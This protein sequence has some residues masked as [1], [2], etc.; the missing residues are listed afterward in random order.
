MTKTE[1]R[2][3][4]RE[5]IVVAANRHRQA[6]NARGIG[7]VPVMAPPLY[8]RHLQQCVRIVRQNLLVS[9]DV[10]VAAGF[11]PTARKAS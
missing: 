4:A 9:D 2:L 5:A 11:R 6:R 7:R 1:H 3:E 8:M 10:L